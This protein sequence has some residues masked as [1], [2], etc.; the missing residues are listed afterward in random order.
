[1]CVSLI[2][3][4]PTAVYLS[5]IATPSFN[6]LQEWVLLAHY[7]SNLFFSH[8]KIGS[9]KAALQSSCLLNTRPSPTAPVLALSRGHDFL[10]PVKVTSSLFYFFLHYSFWRDSRH[11]HLGGDPQNMLEGL[12]NLAGAFP[13]SEFFLLLSMSLWSRWL[14]VRISP[15]LLPQ[16]LKIQE[17]LE[18]VMEG[19]KGESTLILLSP[20]ACV[21]T[22]W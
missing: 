8:F 1:M 11:V 7:F 3:S 18:K 12:K 20:V 16:S 22:D 9:T 15:T 17:E 10:D 19:E 2:F 6:K 4:S 14:C 13:S 21:I 5:Q